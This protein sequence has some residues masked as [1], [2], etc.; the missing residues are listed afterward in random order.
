[1]KKVLLIS[2]SLILSHF[3]SA[4]VTFNNSFGGLLDERGYCVIQSNDGGYLV[5]GYTSSYGSGSSDIYIIKTDQYGDTLWTMTY[6]GQAGDIA[7]SVIQNK[8]NEYIVCGHTSNNPFLLCINEE[9]DIIWSKEYV[10]PNIE[11]GRS[12]IE[13]I[14]SGYLITGATSSSTGAVLLIKTNSEG[15][16]LWTKTDFG[17][18][19]GGRQSIQTNDNGFITMGVITSNPGFVVS[20]YLVKTDDLGNTIWTTVIVEDYYTEGASITKTDDNGFLIV[21]SCSDGGLYPIHDIYLVQ[22][23]NNG[24]VLWDKTYG[25][26]SE[27]ERA[28]CVQI[29][30]DNGFIITGYRSSNDLLLIKTDVN[31]DDIWTRYFNGKG[32]FVSQTDDNGFIITGAIPES[33]YIYDVCLIKTDEAGILTSTIEIFKSDQIKIYPNPTDD[34]ITIEYPNSKRFTL[35]IYNTFGG[36]VLQKNYKEEILEIDLGNYNPGVYL[37]KIETDEKIVTRKIIKN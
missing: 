24:S 25:L 27:N 6:G 37:M 28:N 26:L 22:I 12:V 21:G 17:I 16:T 1:M 33:N 18:S 34:F 30:N 36:I 29:T 31:G 35:T 7:R 8:N 20:I 32:E 19:G 3:L 4:Q 10:T 9:G 2:I 5:C 13:T 23:D 14:D 11:R 15:D